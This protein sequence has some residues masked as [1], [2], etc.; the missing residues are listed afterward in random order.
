MTSVAGR[1]AFGIESQIKIYRFK[2]LSAL[3]P[4]AAQIYPGI[5]WLELIFH[6][7]MFVF[8]LPITKQILI[9]KANSDLINHLIW[10]AI[11]WKVLLFRISANL[12]SV[13]DLFQLEKLFRLTELQWSNTAGSMKFKLLNFRIAVEPAAGQLI[14]ITIGDSPS[15]NHIY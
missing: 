1:R 8:N 13:Y 10:C 12:P 6:T 9:L 2:K 5:Q 7:S 4:K 11:C 14:M 15:I 3:L